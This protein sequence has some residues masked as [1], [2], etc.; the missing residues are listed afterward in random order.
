MTCDFIGTMSFTDSALSTNI[1]A[2]TPCDLQIALIMSKPMMMRSAL[3]Q[4][5]YGFP[6]R[7]ASHVSFSAPLIA[8]AI[9]RKRTIE[10][11]PFI[12]ASIAALLALLRFLLC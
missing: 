7:V 8:V 12:L 5:L 4:V 6:L 9:Q 1:G 3:L 10:K 2:Y 11:R